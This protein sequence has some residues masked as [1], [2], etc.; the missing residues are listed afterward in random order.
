MPQPRTLR[1]RID[2]LACGRDN[3]KVDNVVAYE[4]F[5]G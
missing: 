1:I 3:L 2:D 5:P 4:A